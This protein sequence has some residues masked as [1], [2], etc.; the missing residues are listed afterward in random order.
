MTDDGHV[1]LF[2]RAVVGVP[3]E[4]GDEGLEIVAFVTVDITCDDDVLAAKGIVR[5]IFGDGVR[6][7]ARTVT[8]CFL[9]AITVFLN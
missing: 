4:I 2:V 3:A 8:G 6:S 5:G 9:V 7:A 1:G